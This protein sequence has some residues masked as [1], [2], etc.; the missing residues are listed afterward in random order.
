MNKKL[1][2]RID[3][4]EKLISKKYIK[5]EAEIKPIKDLARLCADKFNLID[6]ISIVLN[7]DVPDEY[8]SRWEIYAPL[9]RD[10]INL[11]DAT[12]KVVNSANTILN[13]NKQ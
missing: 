4:L 3:R 7:N 11:L 5:N 1:E 9:V 2:A 6:D 13:S 10:L 8:D 12:R